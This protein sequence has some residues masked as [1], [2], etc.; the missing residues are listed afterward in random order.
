MRRVEQLF[1][2]ICRP[3]KR[4]IVRKNSNGVSSRKIDCVAMFFSLRE[5][6]CFVFV[7]VWWQSVAA[8]V[9]CGV[10]KISFVGEFVVV[11]MNFFWKSKLNVM[12]RTFFFSSW[13][14][15]NKT[16]NKP[17]KISSSSCVTC[18]DKINHFIWILTSKHLYFTENRIKS[19]IRSILRFLG[20]AGFS[21]GKRLRAGA[22]YKTLYLN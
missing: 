14:R 10:D 3:L 1:F 18:Y 21:I 5:S 8:N 20:R 2:S 9:A 15:K 17:V 12:N 7:D 11:A 16:Q 13:E 19:I 22:F 6:A 4:L